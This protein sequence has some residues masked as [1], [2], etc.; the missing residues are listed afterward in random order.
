MFSFHM[1]GWMKQKCW[2]VASAKVPLGP[3]TPVSAPVKTG[4]PSVDKAL[5]K[6]RKHMDQMGEMYEI[7]AEMSRPSPLPP[8]RG[9]APIA[10]RRGGEA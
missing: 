10:K 8:V 5:A 1:L 7:L 4:K 2:V 3:R 6:S 9:R